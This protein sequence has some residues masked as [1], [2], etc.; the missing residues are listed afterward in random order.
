MTVSS[1]RATA[2]TNGVSG[3]VRPLGYS[4]FEPMVRLHIGV[5]MLERPDNS[6]CDCSRYECGWIQHGFPIA[7][8]LYDFQRE[9]VDK[10]ASVA[11]RLIANEMGT[12]K[13]Y[14]AM[15]L[16]ERIRYGHNER[17]YECD[18]TCNGKTLVIAPLSTL[19]S[20]WQR[21]FDEL[22]DLWV[23]VINPKDRL[24]FQQRYPLADVMICH[25]ESLRLDN[26]QWLN[27]VQWT[28]IIADE[29][30]RIKN[31]NTKQTKALKKIP[32]LFRTALSGTPIMNRP[33]DLWSILNWLDPKFWS[34]YWR[35]FHT[36]VDWYEDEYGY[37]KVRGVKNEEALLSGIDPYFT[38]R[39]KSEVL[40]D[41]PPK[42]YTTIE[43]DMAPK[44][45]KAYQEMEYE[46]L[47]WLEVQ[48]DVTPLSAAVVI[49]QII[50]LQQLAL[51]YSDGNVMSEPSSKID[52][53]MDIIRD[54][55]GKSIVVFSTFKQA[56]RLVEAR[57]KK[58]KIGYG[59]IT[60][61][62]SANARTKAIERFQNK[63]VTVFLGT[64][65]AGSEGIDLTASG[66]VIFLDRD[67]TPARNAQ[68]EDRLHRIGQENA[69]QVIDIVSRD[70]I[71]SYKGRKLEMK[72][73]WIR[74]MLKD[75]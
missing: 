58:A 55:L 47:A 53:L 16:D 44:Q 74:K 7:K 9:D 29:V 30:H 42:Y 54:N 43:V 1:L 28:H 8:L 45:A 41:L 59:R 69:V 5:E 24:Q 63:E 49:A 26:M 25:W 34:S 15:A 22:T 75:G 67:W 32:C 12:G 48:D 3:K 72:K 19:K 66:T 39:R 60:G 36:F 52:V 64:I 11:I 6:N 2:T 71:D 70:T 20:T 31:R 62:D 27:E 33:D 37:K 13:T 40:A 38:R 57:L 4:S 50:R 23:E 46:M 21:H 10:L 65:G 73:S 61:D 35:F 17:H 51:S 56:I 14:E 68:A 18:P